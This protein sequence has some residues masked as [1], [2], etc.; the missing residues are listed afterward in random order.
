MIGTALIGYGYWG[1]ILSRYIEDSNLF[2]LQHIVVRSL[3]GGSEKF[4]T[5]LQKVLDDPK[6]K[7][8]VIA[9]PH[10]THFDLAVS[11]LL[12]GK[13]VLC[14]KPLTSSTREAEHLRYLSY[15]QEKC[16]ETNYLFTFSPGFAHIHKYLRQMECP[17]KMMFTMQQAGKI[18]PDANVF[19]VLGCHLMAVVLYLFG[20]DKPLDIQFNHLFKNKINL[21]QAGK[22]HLTHDG[23]SVEIQV[24][25]MAD[26]KLRTFQAIGPQYEI[27]FDF[28]SGKMEITENGITTKLTFDEGHNIRYGLEHFYAAI[29]KTA[30]SNIED[31]VIIARWLEQS[32]I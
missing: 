16:L 18:Y 7:A 3:P 4:T 14:E 17:D 20:N 2:D 1:K 28:I 9:T 13:H 8:V 15:T 19:E 24:S 21:T 26:E 5:N 32:R 25:L 29:S 10:Q 12:A 30:A 31:S 22:I 11:C 27:Q 6:I 23:F